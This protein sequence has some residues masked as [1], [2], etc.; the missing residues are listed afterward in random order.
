MTEL[1]PQVAARL[2]LQ[3][4]GPAFD[5]PVQA[6]AAYEAGTAELAG[7][8]EEVADVHDVAGPPPL[9]VFTPENAHGTVVFLHGGG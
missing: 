9:R 8:V 4:A 3:L 5:D 2:A 1:D 6:R 7:P